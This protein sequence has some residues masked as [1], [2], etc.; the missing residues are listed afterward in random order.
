MDSQTPDSLPNMYEGRPTLQ[1]PIE[2]LNSNGI[3]AKVAFL[4][5]V[6][7]VFVILLRVGLA[8]LGWWFTPS[9]NPILINGMIDG[10]QLMRIPQDPSEPGAIP[11]LRSADNRGGLVFTWSIWV[12][13]DDLQYN[14]GEYRHIFHK[15]GET[16]SK[17]D[18]TGGLERPPERSRSVHRTRISK[19]QTGS[20]HEYV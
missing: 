6:L 9:P 17:K 1:G 7:I 18:G 5:L 15:G 2:F 19:Q 11:I 16:L 14:S 8:A 12:Y 13:I 3:V 4:I 20:H 10:R